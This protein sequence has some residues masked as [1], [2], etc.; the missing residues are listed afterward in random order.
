[1]S[2][3]VKEAGGDGIPDTT[4]V[5]SNRA[6]GLRRVMTTTDDGLFTAPA[7]NPSAGYRLKI[8]RKGFVDWDSVQ[9]EVSIGQTVNFQVIL[10]HEAASTQ[11]ED[12][13]IPEPQMRDLKAG[14]AS[15]VTRAQIDSLPANRR[16][17]DPLVQMAPA[18]TTD[19]RSGRLVF[20]GQL[21]LRRGAGLN[22][23]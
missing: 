19:D 18:L 10:R 12:N 20:T 22:T 6:L 7:L 9:F 15:L 14:T 3:I 17:A 11:A 23:L 5:L 21:C 4:V 13:N 8:T 16:R 2:G 1:V